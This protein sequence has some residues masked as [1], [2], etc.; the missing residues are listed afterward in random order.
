MLTLSTMEYDLIKKRKTPRLNSHFNV[1]YRKE[2]MSNP[3]RRNCRTTLREVTSGFTGEV[4]TF[5]YIY[6]VTLKHNAVPSI[7]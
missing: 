5:D 2:A 3:T 1:L 7:T 4:V 6:L